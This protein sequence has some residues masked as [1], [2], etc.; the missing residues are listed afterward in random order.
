MGVDLALAPLHLDSGSPFPTNWLFLDR[1]RELWAHIEASKI[2]QPLDRPMWHYEDEGVRERT[3]NPY[4]SPITWARN[5]DLHTLLDA[6]LRRPLEA[7]EYRSGVWTQAAVAYLAHL[8]L[9]TR[10]VLWWH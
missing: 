7:G 10:V 3:T 1:E 8:P 5:Q 4:G 2:E 9:D 6:W